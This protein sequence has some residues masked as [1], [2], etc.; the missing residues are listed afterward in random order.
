MK[1]K[2][3]DLWTKDFTKGKLEKL[4]AIS[5]LI[6]DGCP[7]ETISDKEYTYTYKGRNFDY[8]A[9]SSS[10]AWAYYKTM[11]KGKITIVEDQTVNSK[12]LPTR[13][14]GLFDYTENTPRQEAWGKLKLNKIALAGDCVFNFN[15]KK[16]DRFEKLL[17]EK[18][19]H[20]LQRKLRL[21]A[22]MHHSP[23]NFSFMPVTGGINNQKKKLSGC[24]RPDVLLY[25]I[26]KFYEKYQQELEKNM[27]DIQK[28]DK[29]LQDNKAGLR[30]ELQRLQGELQ[31]IQKRERG[32]T[33]LC[34]YHF[35]ATIGSFKNY[36]RIFY[37]LDHNNPIDKSLVEAMLAMGKQPIDEPDALEAYMNLA[38]AYWKIQRSKYEYIAN[39]DIAYLLEAVTSYCKGPSQP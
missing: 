4:I 21:C 2:L 25:A 6:L 16:V 15:E 31:I 27:L 1:E 19:D 20:D 3:G 13:V 26:T 11:Y 18:K 23:Y 39:A 32:I 29:R 36:V 33:D 28:N 8:D 37:H 34:A 10:I 12:C 30:D 24:D 38:I 22:R 7:D 5:N 35:L 14:E 17:N 9:D